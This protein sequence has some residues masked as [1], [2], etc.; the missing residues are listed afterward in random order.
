[1]GEDKLFVI[2]TKFGEM[3]IFTTEDT[4]PLDDTNEKFLLVEYPAIL[5]PQ[6]SGQLGFQMAF[7]FSDMDKPLQIRKDCIDKMSVSNDQIGKAYDGWK[8]Q[9]KAQLSGIIMPG[10][11]QVAR[12]EDLK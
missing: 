3:I 5:M 4:D 8:T 10:N 1:M 7:P 12:P 11:A 2:Q 9:V 6:K